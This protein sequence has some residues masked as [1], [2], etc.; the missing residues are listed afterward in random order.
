MSAPVDPRFAMVAGRPQDTPQ[1]MPQSGRAAAPLSVPA[2]V[3]QQ[4][5]QF[6]DR[7]ALSAMSQG[8]ARR[9]LSYGALHAASLNAAA[10][11]QHT[12]LGNGDRLGV[13][14][15]NDWAMECYVAA[16]GALTLG[17]VVVP[18]NTRSA[19]SELAHAITLTTPRLILCDTDGHARLSA[20]C[21]AAGMARSGPRVPEPLILDPALLSEPSD[22]TV[23]Q[24]FED[25]GPDTLSCLLFTSGTTARAKAVMHSHRSMIAT[26]IC[27]GG[28]LGLREADIYQGAFPF[29]TSSA[30]NLAAMSCWVAGACL[31][32]EGQI[33]NAARLDLIRTE[34][35]TFYHGV[36]SIVNFMSLA[37]DE[38]RHDLTGLRMLANGGATMPAELTDR[39]TRIWPWITQTQI[40][41]MT[42]SGP[43]G[44]VLPPARL[45]DKAGSVGH[46][47]EGMTVEILNEAGHPV[48]SGTMGEISLSG[49][50]VAL[51]Y[52]RNPEATAAAF[53]GG[54]ILTGD[55]GWLDEEG[56]LWF[57]DRKKDLINRGGLKIASAAVE[58]VLYRHPDVLEAAVVA[59][60][61]PDLGE[62]IAAMVV[63][64]EGV[65]GA[66][67]ARA[68][69]DLCR[70]ALADYEVPRH[71]LFRDS[72]PRNPM[73]KILK[74]D[75]RRD[76]QAAVAAQRPPDA[77]QH[78]DPKDSP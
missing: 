2:L 55:V 50:S 58:N 69:R 30:L 54:R 66:A 3:A 61:H 73:G 20:G 21:V 40:Y 47:M 19:A 64:R 28:A 35:T 29:F 13:Y 44:T 26:G 14:L 68:L 63:A 1:D 78:S 5:R 32:I 52:Y 48:P 27:S 22:Q 31:V 24:A 37:Y 62:D 67:L 38:K 15:T 43:A 16:L 9:R 49:P 7:L 6:G 46:A 75:L 71:I 36:P 42:E 8:Q 76:A 23:I 60:P 10:W 74:A 53:A 56:Y 59:V 77:A 11:L 57:G 17:A 33:D 65:A 18:L 45:T 51:G 72:L 39:I 12:G 25:V 34:G 70:S 41:G 4:A